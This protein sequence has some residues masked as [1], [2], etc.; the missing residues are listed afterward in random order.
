MPREKIT[1]AID[2]VLTKHSAGVDFEDFK[3]ELLAQGVNVRA[4]VTKS[5]QLQ[6]FSFE[7]GGIAFSGSKLGADFG[8]GRLKERGVRPP[9]AAQKRAADEFIRPEP[10]RPADTAR[11]H[12]PTKRKPAEEEHE[13]QEGASLLGPAPM[14]LADRQRRAEHYKQRQQAIQARVDSSNFAKTFGQLG[15][16]LSHYAI[17]IIARFI[18]WLKHFLG[19]KLGVGVREH[20]A[21]VPSGQHK[22][23]LQPTIIDVEAKYIESTS[24]PLLLEQRLDDQL[25]KAG[26]AVNQIVKAVAEKDFDALPGIGSTGRAQLVVELKKAAELDAA[27]GFAA[28][29]AEHLS[30]LQTCFMAHTDASVEAM[31]ANLGPLKSPRRKQIESAENNISRLETADANWLREHPW[32]VK[33]GASA[34][35]LA[36]IAAEKM[37]LGKLQQQLKAEVAAAE[38][39]AAPTIAALQARR[40]MALSALKISLETFSKTLV[41]SEDFAKDERFTTEAAQL[42]ERTK[43]LKL[44]VSTYLANYMA[45]VDPNRRTLIVSEI[46]A[47]QEALDKWAEIAKSQAPVEPKPLLKEERRERPDDDQQ[48]APRG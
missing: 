8:L 24:E 21:R 44:S 41:K 39:A 7:A 18:E 42:Q 32:K 26:Q 43:K 12:L 40:Q 10:A 46:K 1:N 33:L 47:A 27:A 31:A 35:N 3:R 16:A 17:E 37:K 29:A 48:Q 20:I 34:P 14:S 15:L 30:H 13:A 4:A 36:A 22:V 25:D 28:A 45:Q 19:S 23:S 6:G 5:D 38:V 9:V 11:P 2:S